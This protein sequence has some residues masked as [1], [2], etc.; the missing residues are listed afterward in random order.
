M[1][2]RRTVAMATLAV[3]ATTAVVPPTAAA[4][5]FFDRVNP[6][7]P[8]WLFI[9]AAAIVLI[10]SFVAL[11]A[12]W[13]KPKFGDGNWRP[14]PAIV[15]RILTGRIVA[16]VCGATGVVLLATVVVSGLAGRQVVEDNF[17]PIFV[18]VVFWIGLV[19]LSALFG[20]VFRA[21]N[22]WRAIGRATAS[23]SRAIT[24]RPLRARRAYP[25]WLGLWPATC[26][27][28]AFALLEYV[29]SGG[30]QPRTIAVATIVYSVVTFAGMALFGVDR[31]LDRGEGFSVYF[32]LFS[33]VSVFERRA[34]TIGLRPPLAGL[35]GV[36][37]LPGISVL[38]AV[39]I[40]AVTFDSL[41]EG[42]TGQAVI[43]DLQRT[44]EWFGLNTV[45]ATQ[46]ALVVGLAAVIAA[47]LGFYRLGIAGV[48]R[49]CG[50]PSSKQ[51][52]VEFA[53]T[54]VPIAL[55]YVGAHYLTLLLFQGQA[56]FAL[57]SDP[58]G[59]GSD[60]FGTAGTMIDRGLVGST[61]IWYMQVGLVVVGHVAGLML[62][63]DRALV[64]YRNPRD[65]LRSQLWMLGVMVGFTVLALWL[66]SQV[67]GWV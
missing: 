39:M 65:V 15:S 16:V 53:P 54:L 67:S 9:W 36:R 14:L 2:R 29:H 60:L 26:T 19:P 41:G 7:I 49:V 43:A 23:L 5:G 47:V 34:G 48:H 27:L 32:N 12:L 46:V 18:Y 55:A 45:A 57:A 50:G 30:M 52:A 28:V 3:L 44:A 20:D 24:G 62:A 13:S 25:A 33:R 6:P 21:F 42:P 37:P 40:G 8:Q 58:L 10:V 66:L 59:N 61:T 31:W 4:H 51:L 63:H 11:G 22:P 35:A 64:L 1:Q 17:A 38:L 56:I